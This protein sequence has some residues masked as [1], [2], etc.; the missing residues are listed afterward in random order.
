M[1]TFSRDFVV[2]PVSRHF[3][4]SKVSRKG[5]QPNPLKKK[6]FSNDFVVSPVARRFPYHGNFS[7]LLFPD[8]FGKG[9]KVRKLEG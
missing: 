7:F 9:W 2:S 3:L 6:S 8:T 1:M 4:Y 5:K